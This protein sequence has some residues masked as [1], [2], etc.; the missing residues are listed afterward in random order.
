MNHKIEY[1]NDLPNFKDVCIGYYL[2]Y[3]HEFGEVESFARFYQMEV[4]HAKTLINLGVTFYRE[5]KED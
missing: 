5:S 2:S 4:E 3:H 1:K